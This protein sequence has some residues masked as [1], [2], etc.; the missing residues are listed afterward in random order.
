MNSHSDQ[1]TTKKEYKLEL[2]K[3]SGDSRSDLS[4]EKENTTNYNEY[5]HNCGFFIKKIGLITNIKNEYNCSGC[6]ITFSNYSPFGYTIIYS[7]AEE[8]D[9]DQF[10]KITE[11]QVRTIA[12]SNTTPIID[13]YECA[14]PGCRKKL[15]S[16]VIL[17]ES[18]TLFVC[19]YCATIQTLTSYH[20]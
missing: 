19:R 15:F 14:D 3:N 6:D 12:E 16:V 8:N 5:F 2:I 1:N 4:S 13:E 7:T 18:K 17:N 9:D 11:L 10:N 20:H